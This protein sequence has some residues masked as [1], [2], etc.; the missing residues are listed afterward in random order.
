MIIKA[1]LNYFNFTLGGHH[2]MSIISDYK[3]TNCSMKLLEL[4]YYYRTMTASQLTKMYYEL[5]DPLP[6]QKSNIYNYLNKLKKQLIVTSKKLDNSTHSGSIYYLTT[7]GFK[8]VKEMLNIEIGARGSGY[9]ILNEKMGYPTQSDLP[10]E[11]YQPPKKQID[12]HLLLIDFFIQLRIQFGE[13][14]YIDHRLS[15]YCSTKYVLNNIENKIRPDAT[16]LLPNKEAYWIE[17]DRATES[18]SQLLTK[19]QNYKNYISYLEK[20]RLPIPFNSIIFVTDAK[21]QM[22]GLNRR[23]ANI[24]SAFLEIMHPY[25]TDIRLIMTPL[26]KLDETLHF[27]MNRMKLV[28]AAK[29]QI[30]K[31]L[32]DKGYNS[33]H[34]FI[35]KSDKTLFYT[36][37]KK[38]NSYK[39]FFTGLINEYDSSLYTNFHQFMS[40]LNTL[41]KHDLVKGLQPEGF[42]QIVLHIKDKPYVI[43][44]LPQNNASNKTQQIIEFLNRD[45]EFIQLNWDEMS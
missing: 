31:T 43:P 37:G 17:I 2:K 34:P 42:E 7:R 25:E 23:W 38:Q 9:I 33:V 41:N 11:L 28:D 22:Y 35:K 21:H 24:L 40:K 15:T 3:L 29:Q 30:N 12:H 32:M 45:T 39:L 4:L 27:E 10:Y 19:F 16:I 44:S 20:N 5:E 6:T 18:H 13:D 14:D 36:F 8:V 26:N 1:E